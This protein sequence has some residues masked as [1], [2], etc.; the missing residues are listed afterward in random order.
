MGPRELRYNVARLELGK[1]LRS[2]V[3]FSGSH[4]SGKPLTFP[5]PFLLGT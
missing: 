3:F 5:K 2:E 1:N 4:W